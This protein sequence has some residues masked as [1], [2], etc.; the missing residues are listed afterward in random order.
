MLGFSEITPP[1]GVTHATS[2]PFT[3]KDSEEL[4]VARTNLLQVFRVRSFPNKSSAYTGAHALTNGVQNA[5]DHEFTRVNPKLVLVGEYHVAGTVTSLSKVRIRE[6]KS[7]GF[8]LLVSFREAKA[9]LVQWDPEAHGLSTI[10]IH[11]YEGDEPLSSCWVQDFMSYGSYVTVDPSYRCAALRF[12]QHEIAVIPFPQQGEDANVEDQDT[13]MSPVS[14]ITPITPVRSELING[15]SHNKA[16][17]YSSSFVVPLTALEPDVAFISHAIFLHE[18]REPTLGVIY[19]VQDTSD[20]PAIGTLQDSKLY[21][22]YSLDTEQQS[23]TLLFSVP[24]LPSDLWKVVPLPPPTGGS[25]LVG[26]NEIIHV[27]PTGKTVAIAVNDFAKKSTSMR[28]KDRSDWGLQL[29]GCI[30]QQL[31]K[32]GIEF[33]LIPSS[34]RPVLLKFELNGRIVLGLDLQ[35]VVCETEYHGTGGQASCATCIGHDMVFVGSNSVDSLLLRYR[36]KGPHARQGGDEPMINGEAGEDEEMFDGDED[37]EKDLSAQQNGSSLSRTSTSSPL[38]IWVTD[39]LLH[40]AADGEPCLGICGSVTDPDAKLSVVL[41]S[42]PG[43]GGI[44]TF[45]N[46]HLVPEELSRHDVQ[47]VCDVWA[48]SL[49]ASSELAE[50]DNFLVISFFSDEGLGKSRVYNINSQ[51]ISLSQIKSSEFA[52]DARTLSIEV[53][54]NKSRLVQVLQSEIK[55]YDKG[56]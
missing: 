23:R 1:T 35:L 39:D 38:H 18:Y 16:T 54:A 47:S 44:L 5:V 34:G 9:S 40:V 55:C 25:L 28:M 52:E 49:S 13:E 4:V 8:A 29:K 12:A 33:L 7:G 27:D 11:Y 22:V 43:D 46:Q 56:Q 45:L 42:N 50:Y 20:Y 19:S 14:P 3:A 6:T 32:H 21:S 51:G 53:M 2:I 41:P 10:S 17:P 30:F 24:N 37:E 15:D 31:E 48:A 26:N 36:S